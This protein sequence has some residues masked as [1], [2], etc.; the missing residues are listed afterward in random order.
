MQEIFNQA[1]VCESALTGFRADS[2]QNIVDLTLK[3]FVGYKSIIYPAFE[4]SHVL[5]LLKC[6]RQS[7]F[8]TESDGQSEKSVYVTDSLRL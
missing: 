2:R 1:I 3:L 7:L 4:W 6:H 8:I 5:V